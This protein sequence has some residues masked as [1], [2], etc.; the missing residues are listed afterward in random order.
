M[1]AE[2]PTF[3]RISRCIYKQGH[4][5]T[6]VGDAAMMPRTFRPNNPEALW[7][8]PR[9]PQGW[10]PEDHL[11]CFLSDFVKTLSL[12]TILQTLWGRHPWNGPLPSSALGE[13]AVPCLRRG[14]FRLTSDRRG[15][16]G[17]GRAPNSE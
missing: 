1:L 17:A 5:P 3:I 7:L 13:S 10:M 2:A 4:V 15:A 12:T 9:L 8:L 11:V 6:R 14:N 16:M